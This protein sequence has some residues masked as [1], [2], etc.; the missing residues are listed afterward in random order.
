MAPWIHAQFIYTHPLIL[1][2]VSCILI[3]E[4]SVLCMLADNACDPPTGNRSVPWNAFFYH[5]LTPSFGRENSKNN[6]PDSPQNVWKF[7]KMLNACRNSENGTP[8]HPKTS[9]K[10][11]YG[12]KL[13]PKGPAAAVGAMEYLSKEQ[14]RTQK[15]PNGAKACTY[16]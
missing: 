7:S 6:P 14:T 9:Q 13:V 12:A 1:Y 4:T 2:S 10:S 16:I 3:H 5:L 11:Q 8:I 15:M